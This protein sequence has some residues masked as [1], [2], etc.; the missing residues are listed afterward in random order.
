MFLLWKKIN[1]GSH[2]KKGWEIFTDTVIKSLNKKEEPIVFLLWGSYAKEKAM[3]ITNPKHLVLKT[4]HP[5]PFSVRNGFDG[6][7]HFSKANEFL[8]TNGIEP[9]D[10]QIENI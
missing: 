8:K 3:Y 4:S 5:S 6:C 1:L 10:W 7:S 9:I 2:R